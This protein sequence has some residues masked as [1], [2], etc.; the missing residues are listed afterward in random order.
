MAATTKVDCA[1]LESAIIDIRKTMLAKPG[2]ESPREL[3][4]LISPEDFIASVTGNHLF[5]RVQGF[6]AAADDLWIVWSRREPSWDSWRTLQRVSRPITKEEAG[7][8]SG[9]IAVQRSFTR[10]YWGTR[11]C[12]PEGQ[13]RADLYAHGTLIATR[14]LERSLPEMKA[15]R[16]DELNLELCIPTEWSVIPAGRPD[17]EEHTDYGLVRNIKDGA[18][19]LSAFIF[20][21]YVPNQSDGLSNCLVASNA[22]GCVLKTLAAGKF[23]EGNEPLVAFEDISV[24]LDRRALVYRTG[25]TQ[26][27]G[28]HIV[29]AKADAA[30]P[31]QLWNL[32]EL[33]ELVYAENAME[34]GGRRRQRP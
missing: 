10:P 3:K 31:A 15:A 16:I 2:D 14:Y 32:L 1:G 17:F 18:G 5:A 25:M 24:S 13:Y 27:G 7:E 26:D 34:T 11:K 33:V 23:V 22:L 30:T 21:F 28:V 9:P 29:I 8:P 20:S 4:R 12:L 6:D 19:K